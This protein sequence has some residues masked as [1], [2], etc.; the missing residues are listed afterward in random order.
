MLVLIF[1]FGLLLYYLF[2]AG[3]PLLPVNRDDDL[4]DAESMMRAA[5]WFD[6]ELERKIEAMHVIDE[7]KMMIH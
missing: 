7:T 2:C 3:Q 1:V 6:R 5:S 4:A